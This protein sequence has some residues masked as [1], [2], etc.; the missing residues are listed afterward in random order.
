MESSK[1]KNE[2]RAAFA[3]VNNESYIQTGLTKLE[4]FTAMVMQGLLAS[5]VKVGGTMVQDA[6]L[7]AKETLKQL[8]EEK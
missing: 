5:G 7:Y 1:T 2:D 6:I 8:E 4:Y 3:C